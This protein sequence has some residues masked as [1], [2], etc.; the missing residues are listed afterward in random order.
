MI[1]HPTPPG[2]RALAARLQAKF[3]R[4]I[5]VTRALRLRVESYSGDAL[6]LAAPLAPNRNDK[7]TGFAGSLNALMTLAGW[8]LVHLR[9]AEAGESCDIVIHRSEGEFSRAVA[10]DFRARATLSED[11]WD[12]CLERLRARGR[13][14]IPVQARIEADGATAATLA[15]SYVALRRA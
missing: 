1:E 2:N 3:H 11:D 7:G 8:G 4:E 12:G 9:L 6:V 5:P 10:T 14:R 13:G 15:A